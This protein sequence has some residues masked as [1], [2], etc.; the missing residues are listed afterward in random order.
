[1]LHWGR[2]WK[3]VG[4]RDVKWLRIVPQGWYLWEQWQ[5][6]PWR[7]LALML[8]LA[9]PCLTCSSA[10]A[11]EKLCYITILH[12]KQGVPIGIS[13]Q[14]HVLAS[15]DG[16]AFFFN[17]QWPFLTF[18]SW[19]SCYGFPLTFIIAGTSE[20]LL[21][22]ICCQP[23]PIVENIA[24]FLNRDQSPHFACGF[25]DMRIPQKARWWSYL[26]DRWNHHVMW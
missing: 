25:S 16:C 22:S 20:N 6:F 18:Y 5:H 23:C 24:F 10:L 15:V 8:M 9:S 4:N 21:G 2:L 19:L 3:C 26:L 12:G 17:G 13:S 11:L 14:Y 7:W 1:M